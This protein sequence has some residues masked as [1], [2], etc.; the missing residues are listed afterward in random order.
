[1][2]RLMLLRHSKT[3][4]DA[5]SGQDWDRRLDARGRKDAVMVG[6]WLAGQAA[7]R[8]DLVLVSTAVRAR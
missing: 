6:E 4:S 1:M 5:P 3:E 8:P 7:L 2:H